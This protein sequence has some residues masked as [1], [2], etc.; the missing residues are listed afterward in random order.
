MH[1]Q[2]RSLHTQAYTHSLETGHHM[3]MKL[4]NGKVCVGVFGGFMKL[5]N[6]K[7]SGCACGWSR[8]S[9]GVPQGKSLLSLVGAGMGSSC[10]QSRCDDVRSKLFKHHA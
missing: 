3:F 1:V 5:E 2:G 8:N 4:E 6:G 9:T 10:G 7:V